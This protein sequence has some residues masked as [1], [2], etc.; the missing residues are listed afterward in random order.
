MCDICE[1]DPVIWSILGNEY[2][3]IKATKDGEIVKKDQWALFNNGILF[4]SWNVDPIPNPLEY[5]NNFS[6]KKLEEL[7]DS[8]YDSLEI[9]KKEFL[10]QPDRGYSFI[11]DSVKN[12]CSF[13]DIS[14]QY[15]IFN[16]LGIIIKNNPTG[17]ISEDE[18]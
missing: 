5:K 4:S 2:L 14:F 10:M 12:G 9:F 16:Y 15:W 18:L 6:E 13:T 11:K 3:L 1:T 17:T 7:E 8:F